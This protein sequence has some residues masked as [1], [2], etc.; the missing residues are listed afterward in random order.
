MKLPV[1]RPLWRLEDLL[2]ICFQSEELRRSLIRKFPTLAPE[3]P[4]AGESTAQFAHSVVSLL[5]RHG[6]V[7]APLFVHLLVSR[8]LRRAQIMSAA[9]ALSIDSAAIESVMADGER[10]H[11][12]RAPGVIEP[13]MVDDLETLVLEREHAS[14]DDPR[15]AA[16]SEDIERLAAQI[17]A[18][19][20]PRGGDRVAGTILEYLIGR[21]MFGSVWRS[22]DASTGES[23][24]TKI[25]DLSRLTDGVMLWR[26]RRSIRALKVLQKHYDAPPSIAR[27]R[28]AADDGLA[29]AMDY[30]PRGSLEQISQRSWTLADRLE[31]FNEICLA[32]SFAHQAGIIHRDIKPSNVMF[33]ANLRP[34]LIDFDV[35]D[36]RFLTEQK[37]TDGGLGTPMFA[38]PEQVECAGEVDD[39]ADVYSL[40]RLLHYMLIE[41]MPTCSEQ[42]TVLESLARFPPSLSLSVKKATQRHPCDRFG[43]V[44]QLRSDV[45]SYKT[46]MAALR[47]YF[48]RGL[49]GIRRNAVLVMAISSVFTGTFIY[50]SQ[51]ESHKRAM[52]EQLAQT[53]VLTA[54]LSTTRDGLE[55]ARQVYEVLSRQIEDAQQ[56]LEQLEQ[57]AAREKDPRAREGLSLERV[58]LKQEIE[59][60][61]VQ[62]AQ[63]KQK[64]ERLSNDMLATVGAIDSARRSRVTPAQ[65]NGV[66]SSL[67]RV[68]PPEA[69]QPQPARVSPPPP[70]TLPPPLPSEVPPSLVDVEIPDTANL[71]SSSRQQPPRQL[72]W[73][74]PSW[75]KKTSKPAVQVATLASNNQ[76]YEEVNSWLT[77]RT[78]DVRRCQARGAAVN[79]VIM[80]R[81]SDEGKVIKVR[82][83]AGDISERAY[84]CI[85]R[86]IERKRFRP[87]QTDRGGTTHSYGYNGDGSA[88]RVG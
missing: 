84:E 52:A 4:S 31:V 60:L 35:A 86:M 17:R 26:F 1:A 14:P 54:Q 9:C 30:L 77:S 28:S 68:S 72:L 42:D 22:R 38:A 64:L 39:R 29:F 55:E 33:D 21:G 81:V 75:E 37:L 66:S 73:S 20:P 65:P 57:R 23:R 74:P 46:G 47:A 5:D 85:K 49:H 78:A 43:D 76:R 61:E 53:D 18:R 56:K 27:L 19:R 41:R 71:A 87:T 3:L 62:L 25:F 88:N 82:R 2:V 8:P 32:V 69:H 58:A 10:T 59:N 80:L 6:L 51:Q 63:A 16:L 67:A 44:A 45:E 50:A 24:A 36:I 40:G 13:K 83:T 15:R 34:V 48:R 70:R 11:V 12:F 7:D 79:I